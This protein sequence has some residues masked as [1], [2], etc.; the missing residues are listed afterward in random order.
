MEFFNFNKAP[1]VEKIK[2]PA[3]E[4]QE[5]LAQWM[6]RSSM[7]MG[8]HDDT[9]PGDTALTTELDNAIGAHAVT[10]GDA[11]VREVYKTLELSDSDKNDLK[12]IIDDYKM[13]HPQVA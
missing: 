11:G 5:L 10:L 1:V 4:M 7:R 3:D 13:N 6:K 12:Y 8:T 2:T 9:H